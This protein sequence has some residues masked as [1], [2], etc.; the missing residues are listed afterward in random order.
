MHNSR[1][2]KETPK[3]PHHDRDWL[4]MLAKGKIMALDENERREFDALWAKADKTH[5][6]VAELKTRTA[7]LSDRF[8]S[9]ERAMSERAGRNDAR[10]SAIEKRL[11]SL[12]EDMTTILVRYSTKG[13][14]IDRW[15]P[16]CIALV[17][18][19]ISAISVSP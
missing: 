19:I 14:L 8:E 4:Y 1:F 13:G 6:E 17:A 3:T 7:I 5:D 2:I 11:E 9:M 10:L 15:L 16:I 12:K 18:V